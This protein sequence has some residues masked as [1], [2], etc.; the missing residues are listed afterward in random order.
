MRSCV[1]EGFEI[2]VSLSVQLDWPAD[3]RLAL[4]FLPVTD[5]LAEALRLN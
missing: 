4:P 5:T 1:Q 3:T 2:F